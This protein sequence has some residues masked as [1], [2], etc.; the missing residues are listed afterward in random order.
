MICMD[1]HV[2][3][4]H[5]RCICTSILWQKHWLEVNQYSIYSQVVPKG[6][7]CI[8]EL[9]GINASRPIHVKPANKGN[10]SNPCTKVKTHT[11]MDM[12]ID[13]DMDTHTQSRGI[14]SHFQIWPVLAASTAQS[15]SNTLPAYGVNVNVHNILRSPSFVS[16]LCSYQTSVPVKFV[17][18]SIL[19]AC[20][21]VN[22]YQP[23]LCTCQNN[24]SSPVCTSTEQQTHEHQW[25]H[26][27]NSK[28]N[29]VRL[30]VIL[31]VQG[32]ALNSKPCL[33]PQKLSSG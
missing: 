23:H 17:S 6:A 12:D 31:I 16:I 14:I 4:C 5:N 9:I 15:A 26:F 20:Q 2:P 28:T 10:I 13:M 11:D 3:M 30:V 18:P 33:P 29:I 1:F 7:E 24:P 19:C 8:S 22:V 27:C 21:F 32:S 25:C